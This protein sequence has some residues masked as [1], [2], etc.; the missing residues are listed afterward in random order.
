VSGSPR[1]TK[2]AFVYF[3]SRRS[4]PKAIAFQ[5]NPETLTRKIE[6]EAVTSQRPRRGRARSTAT[7]R[8]LITFTLV[9]DATE[10]PAAD[11]GILPLLSALEMLMYA[12]TAAPGSLTL[13]VWGRNR[14]VPVRLREIHIVEQLFDSA[15]NPVRAEIA[16]VLSA[17]G[18]TDF[19]GAAW[20]RKYWDEYIAK[21]Q[22]AAESAPGCT[23]ADLGLPHRPE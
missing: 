6:D 23:L 21:A 14:I 20:A 16:V 2:G 10:Q 1:F 8:Q 5:Y 13:F 4:R 19:A 12:G 15:L 7:P 17:R 11:L 9:L 3:A 18:R 22:E